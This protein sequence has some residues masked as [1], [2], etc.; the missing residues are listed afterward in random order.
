M[1]H[2]S[3]ILQYKWVL[4]L[5]RLHPPLHPTTTFKV[6]IYAPHIHHSSRAVSSPLLWVSYCA[7]GQDPTHNLRTEPTKTGPDRQCR[8]SP[9]AALRIAIMPRTCTVRL[10]SLS[11]CLRIKPKTDNKYSRWREEREIGEG[12][13]G[14][15]VSDLQWFQLH[16]WQTVK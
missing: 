3:F 8:A 15:G 6:T 14:G 9:A 11:A 7:S 13:S 4:L 1:T 10:Q 16:G 12:G 2:S 5:I